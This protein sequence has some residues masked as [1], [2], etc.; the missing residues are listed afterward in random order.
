MKSKVIRATAASNK[1]RIFVAD[2]T[3]MVD[4]AQRLHQAT[5]VAIAALGRTLTATSIMGLMSKSD[6]EKLTVTIDGGGPI[7]QIVT[8]GNST[9]NV[10]GY[11]SNPKVESTNIYPGKLDV[12]R[13]VGK[14]GRISVTRD[15]GLREPYVGSNPLVTGE[16]AED[17]AGYFAFSEQQPSGVALGVL[18]DVDYTVKASGGYIVQ[19]LPGADEETIAK[20][21]EKLTFLEPITSIVDKKSTPEE[22]L[23]HIFK[24]LN[25]TILASYEVDFICDCND[26]RLEKALISIGEKNLTEIIEED[27]HAELVCHFCNT[28]Y[29]F[30]EDHLKRLLKEATEKN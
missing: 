24:D 1:I 22:I 20:L 10:K 26:E 11:V 7:G 12:G 13:A 27:K 14:N 28:K 17:F 21:E 4:K 5:P 9:G 16:I 23:D 25:P 29:Q 18:V 15:L 3:E 2:T 19:V 6:K 30:D 8:V